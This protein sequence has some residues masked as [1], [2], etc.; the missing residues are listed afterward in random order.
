[1]QNELVNPQI[2]YMLACCLTFPGFLG[3]TTVQEMRFWSPYSLL[4]IVFRQNLPRHSF[5]VTILPSLDS[6][7]ENLTKECVFMSLYSLPWVVLRQNLPRNAVFVTM[8]PM[9]PVGPLALLGKA[10]RFW[11]RLG[12]FGKA[13]HFRTSLEL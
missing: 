11:K 5:F 2:H 9:G 6:L 13:W 4:W 3:Q 1:M 12:S 7:N 10:R 8:D